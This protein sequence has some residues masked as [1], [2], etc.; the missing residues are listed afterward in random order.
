MTEEIHE[1]DKHSF[2]LFFFFLIFRTSVDFLWQAN[3]PLT[4]LETQVSQ[5]VDICSIN[6]PADGQTQF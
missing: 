3:A 1:K 2:I 4:L 5:I 6:W